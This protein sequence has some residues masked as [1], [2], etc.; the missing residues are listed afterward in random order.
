VKAVQSIEVNIPYTRKINSGMNA[1]TYIR[2]NEQ[3]I[4][5][6]NIEAFMGKSWS[7]LQQM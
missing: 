7:A 2:T 6:G 5:R 3:E 1:I 4:F